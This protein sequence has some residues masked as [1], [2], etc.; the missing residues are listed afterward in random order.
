MKYSIAI[1]VLM[2]A[3]IDLRREHSQLIST[4][5]ALNSQLQEASSAESKTTPEAV[6]I[7]QAT[8]LTTKQREERFASEYSQLIDAIDTLVKCEDV[9]KSADYLKQYERLELDFEES[10]DCVS[11][12]LMKLRSIEAQITDHASAERAAAHATDV[13]DEFLLL[14]DQ[15]NDYLSKGDSTDEQDADT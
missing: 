15:I 12:H 11:R 6:A 7:M 3:S 2:R 14:A 1:S 5:S 4:L 10:Q 9:E 8:I 13:C